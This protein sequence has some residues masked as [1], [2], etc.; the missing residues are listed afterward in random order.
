MKPRSRIAR[1]ETMTSKERLMPALVREKPDR[2][3]DGDG[4]VESIL[5]FCRRLVGGWAR[6]L[7]NPHQRTNRDRRTSDGL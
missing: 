6:Q 4:A 2:L 7:G 1:L 3:P 5:S